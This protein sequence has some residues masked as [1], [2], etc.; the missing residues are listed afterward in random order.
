MT[1][2]SFQKSSVGILSWGTALPSSAVTTRVI[3]DSQGRTDNPGVSLGIVQKTAPQIDED[4]ATLAVSAASLALAKLSDSNLKSQ[5][6]SLLIGSESHPYAVKPTGTIV[7][8]ALGLPESLSMADLQFAC[9]AGT[10]SLQLTLAQVQSGQIK[11]GLAIGT[12]TAQSKPGDI[13]E[14]AAGA[15]AGAYLVGSSLTHPLVAELIATMSIATDTPDFWRRG[16][17]PY[18]EHAGR[19][20]AEPAYFYHITTLAKQLLTS[21]QLTP[22]DIDYCIFHTPN[23]KFPNQAAKLLGFTPKQLQYSLPVT[24]IG[25]T[26]AAAVPLALANVLDHAL[27]N[28]KIMIVSYGSGAGSDGFIFH[29]TPHLSSVQS[30]NKTTLDAQIKALTYLDL[31]A[32]LQLSRLRRH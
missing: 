30:K 16:H 8:Q 3:A 26:Y 29:T 11:V 10:Q 7:A 15:G 14:Y 22:Q 23:A 32:Y 21:Q 31:V 9:K 28:Q 24:H 17:A 5:L 1:K 4:S 18:P 2:Q 6:G 27:P 12:D 20:S 13:L 19:F 25:N